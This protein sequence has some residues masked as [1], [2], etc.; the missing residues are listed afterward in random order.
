MVSCKELAM[1][2]SVKST[3]NVSLPSDLKAKAIEMSI[4]FSSTLTDA[5]KK[6]IEDLEREGGKP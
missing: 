1:L 6:K 4:P 5:L 3:T 2:A